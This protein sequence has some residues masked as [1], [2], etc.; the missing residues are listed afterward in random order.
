MGGRWGFLPRRETSV[1]VWLMHSSSKAGIPV[2]SK[3]IIAAFHQLRK[4]AVEI[5][6]DGIFFPDTP[7]GGG[8]D[9]IW[10]N[11]MVQKGN[12][13]ERADALGTRCGS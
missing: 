3:L 1:V 4:A 9:G 11:L 5:A 7:H 12:K 10:G 8:G 13:N 2:Q 6:A